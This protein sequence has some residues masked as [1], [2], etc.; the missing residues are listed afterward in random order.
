MPGG[1]AGVW[2]EIP[3]LISGEKNLLFQILEIYQEPLCMAIG[4]PPDAAAIE[5]P[6]L[7]SVSRAQGD[8]GLSAHLTE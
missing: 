7:G 8:E 2:G 3:V 4:K 5:N 6:S 1:E